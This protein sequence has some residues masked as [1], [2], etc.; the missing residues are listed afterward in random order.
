LK[1]SALDATGML[2]ACYRLRRLLT[3]FL[4]KDIGLDEDVVCKVISTHQRFRI[5]DSLK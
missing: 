2:G 4:L 1:A 3:I 5:P